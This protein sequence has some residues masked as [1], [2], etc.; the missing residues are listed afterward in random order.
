MH[1]IDCGGTMLGRMQED[2]SHATLDRILLA[3]YVKK[4]KKKLVLR[5]GG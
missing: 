5:W 4:E 2:P 3:V 1:D